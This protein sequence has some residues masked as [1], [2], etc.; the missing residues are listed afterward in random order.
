MISLPFDLLIFSI[1]DNSIFKVEYHGNN[2][3]QAKKA[4]YHADP[5]G[6]P[7]MVFLH[8]R[9]ASCNYPAGIFAD[10]NNRPFQSQ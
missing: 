10:C 3:E 5:A 2:G 4:T 1:K 6:K 8:H 9:H 7:D